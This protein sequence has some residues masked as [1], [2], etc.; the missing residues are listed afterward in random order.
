MVRSS[1]HT[2]HRHQART[3]DPH[4]LGVSSHNACARMEALTCD[5]GSWDRDR[6]ADEGLPSCLRATNI[7]PATR[8][9][10]QQEQLTV[11]A[12]VN[13]TGPIHK[14]WKSE[15]IMNNYTGL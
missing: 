7:L 8:A 6:H 13:E 2:L 15:K 5:D 9:G 14:A 10:R 11:N 1:T 12:A 3:I 4:G